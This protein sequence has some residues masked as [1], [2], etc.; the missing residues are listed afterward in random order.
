MGGP[1]QI[2]TAEAPLTHFGSLRAIRM[3]SAIEIAASVHGIG[4][5]TAARLVSALE[6]GSI[7]LACRSV[8]AAIMIHLFTKMMAANNEFFVQVEAALLNAFPTYSS[9]EQMVAHQLGENLE[10]I[11]VVEGQK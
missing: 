7:Y 1:R 4:Q 6:L 8:C 11:A 2:E 5:Q 3:A 9:L 10:A